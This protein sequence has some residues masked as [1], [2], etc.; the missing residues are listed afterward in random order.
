[1]NVGELL[2]STALVALVGVTVIG[3]VKTVRASKEPRSARSHV[4]GHG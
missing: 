3:R 2:A 1:M 4:A